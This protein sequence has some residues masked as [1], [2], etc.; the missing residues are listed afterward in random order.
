MFDRIHQELIWPGLFFVVSLLI[1]NSIFLLVKSPLIFFICFWVSFNILYLRIYLFHL[2]NLIEQPTWINSHFISK[3]C[4]NCSYI[5]TLH[6]PL[7]YT[8]HFYTLQVYQHSFILTT[9]SFRFLFFFYQE[10]KGKGSY[11]QKLHV[12]C[13]LYF[14]QCSLFLCVDSCYCLVPFHFILKDSL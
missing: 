4:K 14:N 1:T 8:L 12:Y 9:F 11:K 7:S 3:V 2:G 6:Y 10:G 13:L 5:A